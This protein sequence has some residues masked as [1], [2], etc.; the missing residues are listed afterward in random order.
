MVKHAVRMYCKE[1]SAVRYNIL[2][3]IIGFMNTVIRLYIYIFIY[4][5]YIYIYIYQDSIKGT[6]F[7]YPTID[8]FKTQIRYLNVGKTFLSLK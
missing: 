4:H 2:Y 8:E 5:I 1:L 3:A 7:G 6:S